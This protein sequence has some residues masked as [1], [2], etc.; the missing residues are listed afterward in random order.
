VVLDAATVMPAK[1]VRFLGASGAGCMEDYQQGPKQ[2][3]GGNVLQRA[4]GVVVLVSWNKLER[5]SLPE[6]Q[7]LATGFEY[8]VRTSSDGF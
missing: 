2:Q 7:Q 6:L 3:R 5:I 8:S 1:P 4:I